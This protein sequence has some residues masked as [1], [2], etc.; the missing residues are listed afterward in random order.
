MHIAR[1]LC[2]G[3]AAWCLAQVMAEWE[4][5]MA[6]IEKA[7]DDLRKDGS[8]ARWFEGSDAIIRKVCSL[9]LLPD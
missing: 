2:C 9:V 3:G 6:G 7:A 1:G 5:I 4:R 8:C